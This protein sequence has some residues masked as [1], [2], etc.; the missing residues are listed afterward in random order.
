MVKPTTSTS[1]I[2]ASIKASSHPSVVEAASASASLHTTPMILLIILVVVIL[3]FVESTGT[4][5]IAVLP[6][7]GLLSHHELLFCERVLRLS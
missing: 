2:M 4:L 6:L 1:S 7:L 3:L 5:L